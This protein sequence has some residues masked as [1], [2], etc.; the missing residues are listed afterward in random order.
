MD[1]ARGGPAPAVQLL[2]LGHITGLHGLAGAVRLKLD[3]PESSAL[4][5][6]DRVYIAAGDD[7]PCV[8]QIREARPLNH[9]AV[10][11]ALEGV[12]DPSA[13][14][15]L[16]GA[17][18]L[19]EVASLPPAEADEFYYYEAIGC[20]V[21]TTDGRALGTIEEVFATGANDVWVV[22]DGVTEVLV[23]VIADV[24]KSMDFAGRSVVIEAVPG[25]LD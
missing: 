2:K 24:V 16:K 20:I 25:L 21:R 14:E 18:V 3:N 5:T 23:P 12:T 11:L 22:R 10:R 8:Y 9:S 4:A 17:A 13:A 1:E 15:A 6:I 7:T 19:I